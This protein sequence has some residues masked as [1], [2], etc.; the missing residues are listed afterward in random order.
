MVI[1]EFHHFGGRHP[2]I[3]ALKNTLEYLGAKAPHSQQ[4]YSET[5]LFGL[6]GGIGFAYFLFEQAGAHP[7][8]LGTRFH[9]RETE[10]PEFYQTIAGRIGAQLQLQ[11][12]SSAAAAATNLKRRI[13]EGRPVLVNVD[14]QR[15]PYL[16]LHRS[17]HSYYAVVVYGLE[18]D[19]GEVVLSDRCAEPIALTRDELRHARETSWSPKFRAVLISKPA[20]TPDLEAAVTAGIRETCRH[21]TEGLGITNFGLRGLEKWATVLTSP[22]EKKSWPKIFPPGPAL[23]GALFSLFTQIAARGNTGHAHRSFYAEFLDEA[24]LLLDRPGLRSAADAYRSADDQWAQVADA[25]LPPSIPLF[26]EA[27]EL[28]IRRRCLFESEGPGAG[29]EISQIRQRL[30]DIERGVAENFPLSLP[31]SRALFADLRL[32]ILKLRDAETEA[33]RALESAIA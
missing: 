9:T 31:D 2:E 32:R 4:P 22:K 14:S 33:L 16:G 29:A 6:G 30:L 20:E 5:M 17:L 23:Y 26:Q 21:M 1:P 11:N 15:L 25:H 10:H 8:H 7:I 13:E 27:K 28:A 18:E 3:G 12:S 19:G 24:A